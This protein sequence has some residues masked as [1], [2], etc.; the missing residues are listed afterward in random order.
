MS[1]Y[2][3]E[4]RIFSH[5]RYVCSVP[6]H[7]IVPCSFRRIV[8]SHTCKTY[9]H[10]PTHLYLPVIILVFPSLHTHL[11]RP[12]RL[13]QSPRQTRGPAH[14]RLVRRVPP[15][16]TAT[17]A[18][19]HSAVSRR[20]R[21]CWFLA[22]SGSF[23]W[24]GGRWLRFRGRSAGGGAIHAIGGCRGRWCGNGAGDRLRW[25]W[26]RDGFGIVFC[27]VGRGYPALRGAVEL[28]SKP[29]AWDDY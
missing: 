5:L 13:G 23:W 16:S 25:S 6:S 8:F 14:I 3:N 4:R 22:A 2:L 18:H 20:R 24:R 26:R 19:A 17:C 9:T 29:P 7:I 15:T 21:R 12:Q 27:E 1:F 28:F 11:P 10:A